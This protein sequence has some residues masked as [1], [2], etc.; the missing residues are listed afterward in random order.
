MARNQFIHNQ[1]C[2]GLA[3]ILE[4]TVWSWRSS[5]GMCCVS[6]RY[7]GNLHWASL[8]KINTNASVREVI[9]FI[10]ICAVIRD[11]AGTMCACL[12]KK[13]A[14]FFSPFLAKCIALWEGLIFAQSQGF[15]ISVAE[16]DALRVVQAVNEES[17]L[18]EEGV[19]IYDIIRLLSSVGR[20]E[21]S[22]V[23]KNGIKL[24]SVCRFDF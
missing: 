3:D 24:L 8:L 23:N 16:L 18:R 15:S 21:C 19:I 20:Y 5:K 6:I 10:G 14:G 11:E 17:T 13:I 1:V 12:E 22:H 4:T 2:R 7:D 9:N